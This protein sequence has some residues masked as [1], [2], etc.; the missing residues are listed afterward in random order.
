VS[1]P[2]EDKGKRPKKALRR[3]IFRWMAIL[4]LLVLLLRIALPFVLPVVLDR[5]AAGFDLRL[6]YDDLSLSILGGKVRLKGLVLT[7]REGGGSEFVRLDYARV[8]LRIWSLLSGDVHLDRV[9]ID[10]LSLDIERSADGSWPF[11]DRFAAEGDKAPEAESTPAKTG[12]GDVDFSLPVRID[13][14]QA[15]NLNFRF[16]DRSVSPG[17]E[18]EA[19]L[20]VSVANL[21]S[22]ERPASF[23]VISH[24][25][26]VLGSVRL[27]GTVTSAPESLALEAALSI[28]R[29]RGGRVASYLEEIG[30]VP[31]AEEVDLAARVRL[32]LSADPDDPTAVSAEVDLNEVRARADGVTTAGLGRVFARIDDLGAKEIVIATLTIED[33]DARVSFSSDGVFRALGF[34]FRARESDDSPDVVEAPDD[35]EPGTVRFAKA[36]LVN[37]RAELQN[38]AMIPPLRSTVVAETIELAGLSSRSDGEPGRISARLT[39]PGLAETIL[40]SGEISLLTPKLQGDLSIEIDGLTPKAALPYFDA[41]GVLPEF[42]RGALACRIAVEQ[43]YLDA[44]ILRADLHITDLLVKADAHEHR[45]AI[46]R[47]EEVRV[48]PDGTSVR[49]AGIEISGLDT[50]VKIDESGVVHLLGFRI[51]SPEK[52]GTV[53]EAA[54]PS[55]AG[56]PT[57]EIGRVRLDRNRIR[58]IDESVSPAASIAIEE[59]ALSSGRIRIGTGAGLEP[60]EITLDLRAPGY[61]EEFTVAGTVASP[62]DGTDLELRIRGRGLNA[63]AASPWLGSAGIRPEMTDGNLAIDIEGKICYVDGGADVDLIR[64]RNMSL[65]FGGRDWFGCTEALVAGLRL[66]ED[67]TRIDRVSVVDPS[68]RILRDEGGRIHALGFSF[69]AAATGAGEPPPEEEASEPASF[70]IDDVSLTG[71]TVTIVDERAS[72]P[73]ELTVRLD[74]KSDGLRFDAKS[75]KAGL[76]L[77]IEDPET[78]ARVTGKGHAW[79]E[80]EVYL[81]NEVR[82][83]KKVYHADLDL[84]GER[85]GGER[86]TALLPEGM[87]FDLEDGRL[88]GRVT[89]DLSDLSPHDEEEA[90]W[91]ARL[92]AEN[93]A[94]QDGPEGSPVFGFQKL[95][96]AAERLTGGDEG[97]DLVDLDEISLTGLTAE[98]RRSPDGVVR[99]FGLSFTPSSEPAAPPVPE[100]PLPPEERFAQ[101]MLSREAPPLVK[102]RKLHVDVSRVS[103]LEDRPGA[104]PFVIED[105]VLSNPEP[106]E[107]FGDEEDEGTAPVNLLLTAKAAPFIDRLTIRTMLTPFARPPAGRVAIEVKGIRGEAISRA[108]PTLAE[109]VDLG[110]IVN[111][112]LAAT[113]RFQLRSRRKGRLDF[114]IGRGFDLE[115]TDLHMAGEP[116]GPPLFSCEEVGVSFERLAPGHVVIS[117]AEVNRPRG[118]ISIEEDGLRVMG[119]LIRSKKPDPEDVS[120]E[121]PPDGK[122][123]GRTGSRPE[124]SGEFSLGNLY[125]TDLALDYQDL[126]TSPPV[127]FPLVNT[128]FELRG[129]STRTF[130]ENY[131]FRFQITARSDKVRLP[132]DPENPRSTFDEIALTGQLGIAPIFSGWLRAS[133]IGL[134]LSNLSG[135]AAEQ[136]VTLTDGVLELGLGARFEDDGSMRVKSTL[137][138]RDLSLTEPDGGFLAR[139]LMLPFSTDMVIFLLRDHTGTISFALSFDVPPDGISARKITDIAVKKASELIAKAAVKSPLR[140]TAGIVGIVGIGK[141]GDEPEEPVDIRFE[142]GDAR[143][144]RDSE[145]AFAAIAGRLARKDDLVVTLE[146]HLGFHDVKPM[147]RRSNPKENDCLAL[148]Q[149]LRLRQRNLILSRAGAVEE[150]R[151]SLA[152]GLDESARHAGEQLRAIDRELG[153]ISRE[154]DQVLQILK[155]GSDRRQ[156]R[157]TRMG[158]VALGRMRIEE[159]ARRLRAAGVP[160]H[161]IRYRR[162]RYSDQEEDAVGTVTLQPG[163]RIDAGQPELEEK[164][165]ESA[166]DP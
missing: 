139:K 5:V 158:C 45:L 55:P 93:V 57:I 82:R 20:A 61:V 66:R 131:P 31:V 74:A 26:D 22:E 146:H 92:V 77:L 106:I 59:L 67:G 86:L 119:V 151:A 34:E 111:G 14:L 94:V 165:P 159:L 155:P 27:H 29:F 143:L 84:V 104:E 58:W 68:V 7:P 17:F 137:A 4:V 49:A 126:T 107:T 129:F 152:S 102:I 48:A 160:S 89:A 136:D 154:L 30:L 73:R 163:R 91:T 90:D 157:R 65:A 147:Q 46:G 134:E 80:T 161:R 96:I 156:G 97:L 112:R 99:I 162:P 25:G 117:R 124:P 95:V 153:K 63:V 101:F 144:T 21:G 132:I 130:T 98:M 79:Q 38:G 33:V 116:D 50:S 140:I 133:I 85:M 114:D 87:A 37:V 60:V 69:G 164:S 110:E 39:A 75:A 6:E 52:A 28:D 42:E 105:L 53:E 109:A 135:L 150:A 32:T 19:Y 43:E 47:V 141:G 8:D 11:L 78:G 166:T 148:A 35:G 62:N 36:T 13:A 3:R 72:R 51:G 122:E 23:N 18:T 121:L 15:I 115:V 40:I 103:F 81:K 1:A 145:E 127:H 9:D 16:S 88:T 108:L 149:Y 76:D 56:M 41:I 83:E 125:V 70:G 71:G 128:D 12:A 64:V 120:S 54:P 24:V 138:L 113:I 2:T 10:G 142:D 123:A 100:P 44:D 118:R